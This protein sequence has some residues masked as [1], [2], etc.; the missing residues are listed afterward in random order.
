MCRPGRSYIITG[1]LGGFGLALAEWL[2]SNGATHLVITSSRGIRTGGQRRVIDGLRAL[3]VKVNSCMILFFY[4]PS[5]MF[6]GR[7]FSRAC[8]PL[9]SALR[10][11]IAG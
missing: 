11:G 7:N 8:H 10:C 2:V 5:K 9:T 4:A 6:E 1:G 3:G